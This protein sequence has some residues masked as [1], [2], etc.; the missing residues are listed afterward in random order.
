MAN[1]QQNHLGFKGAGQH[2]LKKGNWES[3]IIHMHRN[4]E[5]ENGSNG[6]QKAKN[7]VTNIAFFLITRKSADRKTQQR[8]PIKRAGSYQQHAFSK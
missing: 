1:L 7:I 4:R 6:L 8:Y 5:Q 2:G 3:G